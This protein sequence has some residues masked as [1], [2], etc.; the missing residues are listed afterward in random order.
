[1]IVANSPAA[2]G[3]NKSDI[4]IKTPD[5]PWFKSQNAT[6]AATA[7]KIIRLAQKLH[8]AKPK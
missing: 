2:I 4:Q 7:K 8:Q 6:K 1:M 5:S 3:A